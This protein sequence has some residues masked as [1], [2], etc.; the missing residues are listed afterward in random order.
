MLKN[1]A[2]KLNNTADDEGCSDDLIVV[3]REELRAV[4]AA[5]GLKANF[6]PHVEMPMGANK[7]YQIDFVWTEPPQAFSSGFAILESSQVNDLQERLEDISNEY[8]D[9]SDVQICEARPHAGDDISDFNGAIDQ[10]KD[11]FGAADMQYAID[12]LTDSCE[13]P[14]I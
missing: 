11:A 14:K 2:E 5:V 8:G 7:V 1:L 12:A 6:G 3:G 10:L 9:I 4:L 13:P